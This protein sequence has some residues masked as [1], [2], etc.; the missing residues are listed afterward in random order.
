MGARDHAGRGALGS[1]AGADREA[2]AERLGD[3]HDV[4]RDTL[5]FM[6]EELAGPPHPALHLVIDEQQAEL[7]GDRRAAP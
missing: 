7:V 3:G 6:G 1:K 2:A 4:G 5:P